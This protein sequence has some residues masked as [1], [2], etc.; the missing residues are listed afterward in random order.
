MRH[1]E[2]SLQKACIKFIRYAYPSV[3]CFSIPNGGHRNPVEGAKLKETGVLAGV[4]DLFVMRDGVN[5]EG[6]RYTHYNGLF[7]EIKVGK[8]VQTQAQKEFE[9]KAKS[10]GYGYVVC[11]SPDEF[12]RTIQNYLNQRI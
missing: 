10:A 3:V 7:I 12:I 4:A 1:L 8:N 2:D 5:R 11:R 6:G 9:S